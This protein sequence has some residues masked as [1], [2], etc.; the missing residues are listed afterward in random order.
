MKRIPP[1]LAK[2]LTELRRSPSIFL[3]ALL[4]GAAAILYPFV[5]AIIVAFVV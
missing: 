5:I 2:E 4:T 3:P 1:L